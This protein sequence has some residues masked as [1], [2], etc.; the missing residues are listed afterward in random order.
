MILVYVT[1]KDVEE[2]QKISKY[3]LEKRLVACANFFP[4]NSMYWWKDSINE[5]NEVALI[6]KT[7]KG[8][9]KAVEKEVKKLHSYDCPC[10]ISLDI[11][12][13]S[14]EFLEWIKKEIKG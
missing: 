4:V 2:A 6:L 7:V 3:L 11:K 10:V 5:E 12:E 9:F 8:K 14:K 13:G 1:C